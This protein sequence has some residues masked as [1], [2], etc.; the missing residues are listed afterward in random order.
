MAELESKTRSTLGG[1]LGKLAEDEE[2]DSDPDDDEVRMASHIQ[3]CAATLTPACSCGLDQDAVRLSG[4]LA[5][6]RLLD[7][8]E[9]VGGSPHSLC[10]VQLCHPVVVQ[11][12]RRMEAAAW[13]RVDTNW[14]DAS[15]QR[16]R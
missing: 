5:A 1:P 11:V 2:E 13:E 12:S 14:L 8:E 9:E 16:R 7:D 4:R 15:G 10:A 6:A 3:P